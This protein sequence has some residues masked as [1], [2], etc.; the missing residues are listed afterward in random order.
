MVLQVDALKAA[1]AARRREAERQ[2]LREAM[3]RQKAERAKH[4]LQVKVS[5]FPQHVCG[6]C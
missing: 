5:T 3:Q 6:Q 4:A 1:E 2:R